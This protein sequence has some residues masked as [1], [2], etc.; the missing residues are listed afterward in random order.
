MFDNGDDMAEPSVRRSKLLDLIDCPAPEETSV[1]G[2]VPGPGAV[3]RPEGD[4]VA[5]AR[6]EFAVLLGEFRRAAVLVPLDGAGDLWSAEQNGVRWICAFSDEAALARFAAARGGAGREWVYR[7]VLG[8]RL[9]DVM[10]PLLPGPAGVALDAGGEEGGV[11]FPPVAG[12]VPDSVA[13]DLGGT[14]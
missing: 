6:R 4:P 11:L 3:L 9:L 14:R 5:V 10:V 2:E 12:I 1:P 8:A 7:R 13:V